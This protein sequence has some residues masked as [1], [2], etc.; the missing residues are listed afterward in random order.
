MKAFEGL[1]P[2]QKLFVLALLKPGATLKSAG[3]TAGVS[4]V[5]A[6]RWI[7]QPAI[8]AALREAEAEAMH[9][10]ARALTA[11]AQEAVGVLGAQM[12]DASNPPGVRVRAADLVLTRLLQL[13][14]LT[15]LEERLAALEEIISKGG[16]K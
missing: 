4:E 5:T 3:E 9:E 12:N 10:A 13:R 1:T 6:Q 8:R 15:E 11:L 7:R 16:G 2:K 14:E